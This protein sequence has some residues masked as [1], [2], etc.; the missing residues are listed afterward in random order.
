MCSCS[1]VAAFIVD[2]NP[3]PH[4]LVCLSTYPKL[5]RVCCGPSVYCGP[6]LCPPPPPVRVCVQNKK[7]QKLTGLSFQS[8]KH[9]VV[10]VDSQ[11]TA[12]VCLYVLCPFVSL[13]VSKLC[14]FLCV[15]LFMCLSCA[16][17]VS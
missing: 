16:S 12:G 8:V 10:T 1:S 4:T 3:K 14:L 7:E 13:C 17:C 5:N 2:L 6:K 9:E 11:P 15:S